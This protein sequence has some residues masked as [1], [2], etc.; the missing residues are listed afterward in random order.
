MD[1]LY[2]FVYFL[3]ISMSEMFSMSHDRFSLILSFQFSRYDLIPE[4][5]IILIIINW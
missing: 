4:S 3:N 1:H 5:I 2:Y